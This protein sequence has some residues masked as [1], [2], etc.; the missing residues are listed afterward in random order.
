MAQQQRAIR[1]RRM[2]LEAAAATFDELGYDG[3][4]T[5]EILSRSGLTRGALYHHFPSKEAIAAALVAAQDE[6]LVIPTHTVKL[7]GVIDLTAEYAFRLQTDSVLRAGVR[8]TVEQTS[9]SQP[10]IAPYQGA[11]NVI[12]SLL[13]GAQER[14]ELLPGVR[15]QEVT[16][17]IVGAFTGIQLLSQVYDNRRDLL[18]RVSA[19]WRFL[20]PG[21]AVP[22]LV[23]HLDTDIERRCAVN[24]RARQDAEAAP[25]A[26]P[27]ATPEPAAA[28]PAGTGASEPVAAASRRREPVKAD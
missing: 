13:R 19:M 4:S 14:G 27:E 9:F 26:T 10:K 6:A 25:G 21:I 15:P 16:E 23:P 3:A 11:A 20:L 22:G 12:G 2:I 18:H 1:T 24:A 28:R 8:L 7:Q 17:F 5:T